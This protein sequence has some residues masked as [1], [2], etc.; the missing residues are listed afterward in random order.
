MIQVRCRPSACNAA[1]RPDRS[2][3]GLGCFHFLSFF[4]ETTA[5]SLTWLFH[6]LRRS[7]SAPHKNTR[8]TRPICPLSLERLEDRTVPAISIL[9]NGG[10]GY[11][12]LS[13]NQSGGYVP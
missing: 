4:L 7:K 1:P 6:S 11:A 13:F 2:R 10:A 12:A 9:N 5:M 8:G 3:L